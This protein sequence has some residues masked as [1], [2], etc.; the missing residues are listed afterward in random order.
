MIDT[1]PLPLFWKDRSSVFLG[2]NQQFVRILGAPSS[3]EVVGKTD[4]DL[5]PTEEEASAFQADDRGVMESG[6]AKLGIEEMLTFANGEQRWLETHKAPLRDWSG[7][8][9]GMVGTFQDVTDRKQAELELQKNTERLVFA[10]KSGAKEFEMQLQQ[11]TDRLSLALNSG[12]IG[13]WEWDIQQNILVWDDRMYELYGYLKENYSHLPYEI[14]ANAVHPDDRD[15]TETL[16]QQ[17]VLGKTEYDCEFRIIHPDHSIHFIKAYGTLNRDASGNP[18]SII[19]INFDITDRKQAEQIIL[20]QANRETL[21]RGIT[22]RIR[23]YLDL[24]IIFDTACQ[25]IQQLLQSDRVGI[26]KF[27]PESNFDDGEFVAESVVNGFSSAME[28]HIHDHCFGE[29][30]AAEYA[31]GRMQVVN[32]ID[33]AGLMDCHRDV[34]AQ[35]QVRANLA[36]PL[37]CGNNLWGLL[38]IHQCAHTRQWQED[39]INLIQQIANQLAIAIQQASLYEQLQEELLI[40]QQSQSKIAQQLREQQTLATITNKIRESLSIKEILAVVTQQVIDVLSGD[41]AIIFQ[42]FDNG[43]SQIVEESV[44]SN[45]LNLKALNWDNEVWSQEILDC[46]WQGKPR[47][48]PDVMNDIWTECLVEYSLKGQIKSK[49]VAPILLESHISENH[50]WV[51][52]DGYKKLW[53][54]LVVHACAEQREWQDSEA[55][56]LQQVANQLAIAIQQASIY[57]ESQQEIAERKQAEQQLTET[58]QQLARAT[59]LKDE[60]LANMSHELRTPLNSILGMNEALQEEVFGGIN[61]RQLKALQTIESSSRHLLALINDILDVAK[62]ESGQ[63]TLELTATDLDSL[64]QSSL[65]FIKQQALAKRIKLIPRIPKHLPEIMLDE[66]R[67]RQVLINLLNNAVKFTLEGGTIT[68]EVSQVQ[69]ESSTTNP[70]PLNYLKIAVIDTGIGISAENI[71]KL[72]QPFIQIDSALN[73]QYNGT[74]LGLALVKRLVEIHGGT[75]ELTSELGVGSC[76][77]INLPINVGFPAIEEQ[78]EQDLSGQSQI[79]QSQTEGLISPLILL[80]EDNE[81]NI[82]TFSSY[83]EAKGYRILLANDGQQAIDLAKA[84]HPD[85]ILMDI[86]MPVMDGLEAIKQIRLDPNLADIPIIALTALVMEGDHERCLAVGANEYLSK[87]IKL[88]QL[89]TIIQQIL[90]RT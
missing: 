3:K 4:F 31:Q 50:R 25:E 29:G 81:A 65:A 82:V 18:L 43:N 7:N 57:E 41:R 27:Y 66:R 74:G 19:G 11:T 76:F 30:Y 64:C 32:D 69:R 62:I 38:S 14:W 20:Q 23:Q 55:Q 80:A 8:V 58:N 87:P 72:F 89:A 53:G 26:F 52:T 33:N 44:H 2:C 78:T 60:F 88:K 49:I 56:L 83:L 1:V 36:I 51:A 12:A 68:L 84:E 70:T 24:S 47:I 77:A 54:V 15:L 45:F 28:V 21:L 35:F 71:Q 79:G 10:L 5:L 22:Q 59:R 67:I 48:V 63:V 46:Y 6:Q 17:A 61:E 73:R 40:R 16:L 90:V 75:V 37:L 9:I 13:Y 42:L 85:L 39:E 86:Q 34:L